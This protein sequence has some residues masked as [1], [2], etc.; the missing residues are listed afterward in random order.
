[1]NSQAAIVGFHPSNLFT[2]HPMQKGSA[3]VDFNIVE[4]HLEGGNFVLLSDLFPCFAEHPVV[5]LSF[6]KICASR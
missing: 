1:M 3:K 5:F 6:D 2:W 4:E